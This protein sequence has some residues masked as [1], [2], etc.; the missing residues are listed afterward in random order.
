MT[1][2]SPDCSIRPAGP[3]DYAVIAR[4]FHTAIHQTAKPYYTEQELQ[5]WSSE[6]LSADHW[7]RRTAN[8]IVYVAVVDG[9]IGGFIGFALSGHVDLLF[10]RP[11]L[12]RCGIGRGLLLEAE[13]VVRERGAGT[14][15]AE[16]S[17][18]A[19]PF[20]QAM[21][22]RVVREQAVLCRGV[23]LRNCRMEKA[24]TPIAGSTGTGHS[25]T[26]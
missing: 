2:Q 16:V 4:I 7:R 9:V 24:L 10:T 3:S 12:V 11:D 20:F 6:E 26:R 14:A 23:S 25:P 21:G 8:L 13:R 19:Q 18:A 1:A 5:A 15:W 22:Y 17:L